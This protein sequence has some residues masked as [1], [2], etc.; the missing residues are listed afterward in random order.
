VGSTAADGPTADEALRAPL[1]ALLGEGADARIHVVDDARVIRVAKD[2][3]SL[4]DEAEI[5]RHAAASGFPVPAVLAVSDDGERLLL[6][7]IDGPSMLELLLTGALSPADAGAQL[8]ALHQRLHAIDAPA[9]LRTAGPGTAFLHL[10]LH[11]ANVLIATGGPVVIDWPNAAAGPAGLDV[12]DAYLTMAALPVPEGDLARLQ[13][14]LI[15]AFLAAAG[16]PDAARW[17]PAVIDRRERD[18]HFPPEWIER[19]RATA[20]A[21]S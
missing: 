3:R 18:P 16:E 4:R 17:F 9:W 12:A 19:M 15:T 7:R 6:E 11:P 5:Q 14:D 10:D 13:Q 1:G 8:G 21:Q 20:A 2:G